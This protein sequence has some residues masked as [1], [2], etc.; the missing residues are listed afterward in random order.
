MKK[1]LTISLAAVMSL[2]LALPALADDAAPALTDGVDVSTAVPGGQTEAVN[3]FTDVAATDY[4]YEPVLWAVAQNITTGATPTTFEPNTDC[5]KAQILTFLYRAAGE[6]EVTLTANPFTDVPEDEYYYKAALWAAENGLVE[7]E[8]FLGGDL[9]TRAAA[10]EYIWKQ[11]GKPAATASAGFTDVSGDLAAAADWAKE[12]GVTTG[13]TETTFE[14]TAICTRG[15]IAAFL[16]RAFA[17]EEAQPAENADQTVDQTGD[18][19][20]DDAADQA[21]Q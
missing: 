19:S 17:E 13:A 21:Q 16:Y 14:P 5:T 9:C 20:E 2:G 11:A 10:V 4:F 8:E 7:G 6:P 15:Q 18:Q 3:P 12:A 1:L